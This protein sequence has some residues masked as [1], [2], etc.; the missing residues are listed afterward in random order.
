MRGHASRLSTDLPSNL[1]VGVL[2]IVVL[3]FFLNTPPR[4][5]KTVRQQ[6]ADFDFGGLFLIVGRRQICRRSRGQIG[7]VIEIVLGFSFSEQSWATAR[8]IVLIALGVVS[9]IAAAVWET[10]TTRTP[11]IPPRLWATRTTALVL[12]SVMVHGLTFFAAAFCACFAH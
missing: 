10:R 2:A 5:R 11:I 9:L 8:T 12:V 1:P 6:A 7:G 3:F 4:E